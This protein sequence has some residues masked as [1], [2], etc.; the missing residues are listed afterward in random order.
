MLPNLTADD[1]GALERRMAAATSVDSVS[2]DKDVL[3]ALIEGWRARGK[4]WEALSSAEGVCVEYDDLRGET[5]CAF[6]ESSGDGEHRDYCPFF[7]LY[8]EGADGD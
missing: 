7:T 2:V 1:V 3:A 8:E 5:T 6:C 4:L